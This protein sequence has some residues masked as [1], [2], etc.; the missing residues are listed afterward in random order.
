MDEIN[1]FL[2]ELDTQLSGFQDIVLD[3]ENEP[4]KELLDEIFRRVHTVKGVSGFVGLEKLQ[5]VSH[6]LEDLLSEIRDKGKSFL[7]HRE[8]VDLLLSYIDYLEALRGTL[9]SGGDESS[10]EL[11]SPIVSVLYKKGETGGETRSSSKVRAVVKEEGSAERVEESMGIKFVSGEP[12]YVLEVG[13]GRD[14]PLRDLKALLIIRNLSEQ[15]DVVGVEPDLEKIEKGDFDKLK[16]FI[17]AGSREEAGK[18][19]SI[20]DIEGV[21]NIEL[22]PFEKYESDFGLKQEEAVSSAPPEASHGEGKKLESAIPKQSTHYF[23]QSDTV[24]VSINKLD[25]LLNLVGELVIVNSAFNNVAQK[26]AELAGSK[27]VYM[28]LREKISELFR[29]SS[30]LQESIMRA[31]M[32]PVGELFSR[33]KRVVR[34]ISRELGKE[35]ELV[36]EGEDTE[37]DKK[38]VDRLADPL[39]H[40]VRNAIDHGIEPPEEREIKG[41]P[42]KG[43]VYLSA[44][45]EGN[46]VIISVA[47]DGRGID[48][49]KVKSKA[50][51]K[52]LISRQ[53]ADSLTED[54]IL[55]LIF[56]PGFSTS[57][58]VSELSGRGVGMDVVKRVVEELNGYVEVY[59]EKDQGTEVVIY[60]PL[61]LAIIQAI[62]FRVGDEIYALPIASIKEMVEISADDIYKV[63]EREVIKLRERVVSVLRLDELLEAEK[64]LSYFEKAPVIVVSYR[65]EDIAFLVHELMDTQDIVIKPLSQHYRDIE[66]VAGASILG[67]GTVCLILDPQGLINVALRRLEAFSLQRE[68]GI[69]TLRSRK[70]RTLRDLI[71]M[72]EHSIKTY[73]RASSKRA[74]NSLAKLMGLEPEEV[75]VG[76]PEVGIIRKKEIERVVGGVDQL[77]ASFLE[78]EGEVGAR[79][80]IFMDPE[81]LDNL[82]EVFELESMEEKMSLF[83]ELTNIFSAAYLYTLEHAAGL[84]SHHEVARFES[85]G[86]REVLEKVF[87]DFHPNE[88]V[89]YIKEELMVKERNA[90]LVVLLVPYSTYIPKFAEAMESV[91]I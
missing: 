28:E 72:G 86:T 11:P 14:I 73:V 18:A 53:E 37:L 24:R 76:E 5:D 67:D 68:R 69:F 88:E 79:F 31:R 47:D 59:T 83:N 61:T 7:P 34:D 44:A 19:L 66:G 21:D 29:I 75:G 32:V 25:D 56:L 30:S 51:E 71:K 48:L 26:V 46:H 10:V 3:Y 80:V 8:L 55:D 27:Q 82:G 65:D 17:S 57:N 52:G 38:V 85:G 12:D 36:I 35:V 50:V 54:E 60:L 87:E 1:A 89:L 62:L 78:W 4:S 90:S 64:R 20:A 81:S 43:T 39:V 58:R 22:I 91:E 42:R 15:L 16:I 33:F 40:L 13:L 45:H 70:S 84:K 23:V 41:K 6:R 9:S 2:E 49:E 77:Y 74:A 63:N